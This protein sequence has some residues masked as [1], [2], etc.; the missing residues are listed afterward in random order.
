MRVPIFRKIFI[1]IIIIAPLFADLGCKKQ[2]KCGCGKDVIF[3][4]PPTDGNQPYTVYIYYSETS[5]TL[6]FVPVNSS[7]ASYFFCNPGEWLDT[8]KKY[9]SGHKWLISGDAFYECSYL[10][11][12]GNSGYYTPPVYQVEVTDLKED[13]YGKK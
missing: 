12:S 13:N 9:P 3:T 2:P 5:S 11:N 1:V 7:G 8:I 10:M 6:Q 4:I